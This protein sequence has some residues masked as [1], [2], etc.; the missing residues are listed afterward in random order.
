MNGLRRG[1]ASTRKP[2]PS[3]CLGPVVSRVSARLAVPLP[4]TASLSFTVHRD[5]WTAADLTVQFP[6]PSHLGH[7][8]LL[9]F[10]HLGYIHYVP[11]PSRTSAS[12]VSAFRSTFA[13]FSSHSHHISHIVLDNETTEALTTFFLSTK[14]PTKFQYVPPQSHRANKAERAIRTAKN[15]FLS[16]LASAH[17]TFPPNRWP[18]LLPATELTLNHLRRFSPDPSESA[19][20]GIQGAPDDFAAHPTHPPGQLFVVHDSPIKRKSW[21]QHGT[22]AFYLSPSLLH[23][24]SHAVFFPK[25]GATRVSDRLDHFPDPLFHFES[26]SPQTLPDPSDSRPNPTYDGMDLVGRSFVD[27][28]LG[29]CRVVPPLSP[30]SCPLKPATSPPARASPP[31]GIPP[32]PTSPPEATPNAP[33]SRRSLVGS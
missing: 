9:V 31:D 16:V 13:F 30:S 32:S 23:Y 25:T 28:E 6:N 2:F 26:L 27:P 19:W 4:P 24:R 20:H 21:D 18:D 5:E 14:L 17:V 7:E 29:V 1:I 15:H 3:S 22:H 11:M 10:L 8:Y 33:P 12:Y